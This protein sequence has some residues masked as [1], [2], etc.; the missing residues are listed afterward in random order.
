MWLGQAYRVLRDDRIAVLW[1]D[2]RQTPTTSD[3]LQGGGFIWRG[4]AEWNKTRAARPRKGGLRQQSEYIL[5]GS[6]GGVR[7]AVEL[8]DGTIYEVP[9]IAGSWSRASNAD[10][11]EHVAAKPIPILSDLIELTAPGETVLDPF[12]GSGTTG[13]AALLTGRRFVGIEIVEYWAEITAHR[14]EAAEAGATPATLD[15]YRAGQH[16]LFGGDEEE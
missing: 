13:Q 12:A 16:S 6:K 7:E 3:A 8:P 15:Q 1:S 11:K 2:W 10:P 14:L 5:W 4:L 9:C